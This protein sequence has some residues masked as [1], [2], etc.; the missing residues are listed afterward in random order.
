M[1]ASLTALAT[2]PRSAIKSLLTD[3]AS[4]RAL[5]DDADRFVIDMLEAFITAQFKTVIDILERNQ[6]T[7]KLNPHLAPHAAK[8]CSA[9]RTRACIQYFAPFKAVQ[10]SQMA[11]AFGTE[12]D[13][14][15]AEVVSLV[16]D[17]RLNARVDLIDRVGCTRRVAQT[18]IG[19]G[20]GT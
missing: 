9:I 4:F 12:P 19:S 11:K 2:L 18:L 5:A 14:M 8:I 13:A 15:L 20:A 17:G 7:I 10:I 16:Q 3:N 1:F 6:P